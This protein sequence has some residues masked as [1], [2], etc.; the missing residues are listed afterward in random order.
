MMCEWDVAGRCAAE[1][2][3]FNQTAEKKRYHFMLFGVYAGI[4]L[5]LIWLIPI[6]HVWQYL[7]KLSQAQ[8]CRRTWSTPKLL[9]EQGYH[10]QLLG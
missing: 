2:C 5:I 4:I 3:K 7:P 10:L 9:W 6:P 1:F 8:V